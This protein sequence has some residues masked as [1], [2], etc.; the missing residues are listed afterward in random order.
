[1]ERAVPS[2]FPAMVEGER[3]RLR[4]VN[5]DD[6]EATWG[7]ASRAEFFRF[8]PIDQPTRDEERAWLDSVVVEAHEVPRRQ[9]ELGIE[10]VDSCELIGMVRLGVDSERHRSASIGYGISPDRWGHGYATEAAELI[11]GFGFEPSGCTAS[12]RRITRTTLPPARSWRR[13]GFEK[14]GGGG[15]IGLSV[16]RGTTRSCARSSK[17]IGD[18]EERVHEQSP[19]TGSPPKCVLT[20]KPC[21]DRAGFDGG[22]ATIS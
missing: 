6:F 3:V 11:V 2:I 10:V 16:A 14:R 19:R 18:S 4:E 15:M 7:W 9:Y 8:L 5:S 13:S 21:H 20:P 1:M 12:G 22:Q 17:T